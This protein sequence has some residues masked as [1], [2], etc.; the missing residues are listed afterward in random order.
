MQNENHSLRLRFE[1]LY[2]AL[3][4]TMASYYPF[5]PLY[6]ES[7][8]LSYIQIGIVF[9]INSLVGIF[10]QP[11]WGY[12]TDK[13]LNKKKT[14]L[15][16]S[17]FCAVLIFNFMVAHSFL[18][19]IA[20]VIMLLIFQSITSPMADAYCYEV[21]ERTNAF[22]FGQVRLMGSIGFALISAALGKIIQLTDSRASFLLFSILFI[23]TAYLLYGIKFEGKANI[24]RPSIRD[25]LNTIKEFKF[26]VFVFSVLLLNI[27]LGANGSY[28]SV[29][30][31]E[32][33]GSVTILG[34]VWFIIAISEIPAFFFGNHLQKRFGELNI[35]LW[36]VGL[37]TL[38]FLLCSIPQS[39]ISVISIQ[40][41][42]GVTFPLYLMGA[43]QYLYKI[44][45]E[46]IK[47]SG[48]TL[49]SSLG[50]GLGSFIGN[51]GGGVFLES[52]GIH[53]LYRILSVFCVLALLVGLYLK[54]Q[55]KKTMQK[56]R[57][58]SFE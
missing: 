7:R 15:I 19:I 51:L 40:L 53:L 5:L 32:T 49:L 43:M 47:A 16:A 33:G 57:V 42:Q 10:S 52:H 38:R 28:I 46:P 30:V 4:G 35:Y 13:Y 17:V 41:L 55:D 20:S 34:F 9:A 27:A 18:Y 23:I 22:S 37:Y 39:Y 56:E 1:L 24:K 29:L 8:N 21:I 45:P 14:L 6:L 54:S 12:V 44:V 36:A 58:Y 3:F 48:I 25:V 11:I 26:M 50:F 31:K 2:F